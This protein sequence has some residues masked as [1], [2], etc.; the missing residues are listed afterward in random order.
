MTFLWFAVPACRVWELLQY[1]G[2]FK[3]VIKAY[4]FQVSVTTNRSQHPC[5]AAAERNEAPDDVSSTRKEGLFP[6][7]LTL[8]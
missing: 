7:F 5:T 6:C 4:Y 3:M 2:A 1:L 8:R